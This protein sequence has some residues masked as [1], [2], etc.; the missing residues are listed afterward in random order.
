MSSPKP[1]V[2]AVALAYLEAGLSLLPVAT[3]GSKAPALAWKP[4]QTRQPAPQELHS[5][6]AR[7]W[8]IGIIG[9]A[10]SGNLEILDC[11]A[12]ELFAP[13]CDMM[14]E[15]APGLVQRLPLVKTPSNGRHVYYRC[16]EIAG[17]Q[18]LA[19]RLKADGMAKTLIETRG[20]GGYVLS[21]ICPPACHPLKKPYMLL[22]GDLAD[23][24]RITT[25]ERAFLLN[26]ARSFNAYV[27]TERTI[28]HQAKGHTAAIPGDRP[29]DVFNAK[30]TWSEI[31]QP[32]GWTCI[33]QRGEVTLWKRPGKR[34]RGWSATTGYGKSVTV[35]SC[36]KR[37]ASIG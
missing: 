10:V 20:E 33:G 9:G 30:A 23:I 2:P 24:S 28:S 31:L 1:T 3:D 17:N 15:L 37:H 5:W 22:D 14:E 21:P 8:G 6:C 26:A 11:D 7:G 18:K 27:N 12:P 35:L 32:H 36:V 16:D 25:D 34:E 29:G 13:W 4:Y 19:Q